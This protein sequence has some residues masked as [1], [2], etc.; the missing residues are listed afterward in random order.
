MFYICSQKLI[1][2]PRVAGI[3]GAAGA[4]SPGGEDGAAGGSL[5]MLK[6][7]AAVGGSRGGSG[8]Y[9]LSSVR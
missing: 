7:D 6:G 4:L 9:F 2:R 3:A 5:K 1:R 8:D